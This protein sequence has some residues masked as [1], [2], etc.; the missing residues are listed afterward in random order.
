MDHPLIYFDRTKGGDIGWPDSKTWSEAA[1]GHVNSLLK[2][3]AKE[4]V[5]KGLM[6]LIGA[7][8]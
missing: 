5:K 2:E 6:T 7:S 4:A 8:G 1:R 3:F